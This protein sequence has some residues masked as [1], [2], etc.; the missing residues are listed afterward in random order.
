MQTSGAEQDEA[1]RR[2]LD[3]VA[4]APA[5]EARRMASAVLAS[6]EAADQDRYAEQ[7]FDVNLALGNTAEAAAAAVESALADQKQGNYKVRQYTVQHAVQ[8]ST[9]ARTIGIHHALRSAWA[10][11]SKARYMSSPFAVQAA[12][13][14]LLSA[15]A[16]LRGSGGGSA[17]PTVLTSALASLHSYTLVKLRVNR[18]DH[19]G[20]ARLL[21]RVCAAIS[22]FERH[23]ARIMT[24]AV[25]ECM[26]AGLP[27]SA[28][29]I[30]GALLQP[31]HR[32]ALVE[33][34]PTYK[35]K[36]QGVV[37]SCCVLLLFPRSARLR[38][39]CLAACG[40]G[41]GLHSKVVQWE[42]ACCW[43]KCD[44]DEAV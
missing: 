4:K 27:E 7:L 2:S 44:A 42:A 26:R 11:T 1:V 36:I 34:G 3:V 39:L 18:G 38:T 13:Y 43:V 9:E 29:E 37:R 33:M 41:R 21:K 15:A 17:L 5:D 24:S 31:G 8:S 14:K 10:C 25:M 20:A 40:H 30:A 22:R 32:K 23:A 12:R 19:A 6:M 28:F 35:R 16:R